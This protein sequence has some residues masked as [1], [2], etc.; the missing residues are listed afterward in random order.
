M[1]THGTARVLSNR[2][3]TGRSVGLLINHN[4]PVLKD[5]IHR[6]EF[7]F[8]TGCVVPKAQGGARIRG[9]PFLSPLRLGGDFSVFHVTQN[10]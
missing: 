8:K 6:L 5:G 2:K 10:M 7:I 3:L 1:Q 9:T 4:A